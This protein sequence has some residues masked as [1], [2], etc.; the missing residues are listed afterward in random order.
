MSLHVVVEVETRLA[1]RGRILHCNYAD[2]GSRFW[3]AAPE[4]TSGGKQDCRLL[5]ISV[6]AL[7][8]GCYCNRYGRGLLDVSNNGLPIIVV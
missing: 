6:L 3:L 2:H 4:L 5:T 8:I 1:S 7:I